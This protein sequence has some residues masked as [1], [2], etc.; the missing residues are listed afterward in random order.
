MAGDVGFG[1]F[2]SEEPSCSD[3]LSID[4]LENVRNEVGELAS[5]LALHSERLAAFLQ[6][7][8]PEPFGLWGVIVGISD[9]GSQRADSCC[10]MGFATYEESNLEPCVI[11]TYSSLQLSLLLELLLK[12]LDDAIWSGRTIR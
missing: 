11:K 7:E 10:S 8:R 9:E 12:I 5:D 4:V 6:I 2:R 3:P 1:C